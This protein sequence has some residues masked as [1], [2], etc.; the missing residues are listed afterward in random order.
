MP[1]HIKAKSGDIAPTVLLPGDPE[2]ATFIAENFL[3]EPVQYNSYRLLHGYTGFY[4]GNRISVQTTGM[5]A[6]SAAIVIKELIELGAQ[7]FIRI[8]TC[9]DLHGNLTLGQLIIPISA[10]VLNSTTNEIAQFEGYA[11]SPDYDLMQNLV[12]A[13]QNKSLQ[14]KVGTVGTMDLFYHPD[15]T[16]SERCRAMGVLALEMET[17]L[18]FALAARYR[19]RAAALLTV[20]DNIPQGVRAP[21]EIISLG[22]RA[23]TQVALDS[24]LSIKE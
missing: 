5:G 6:P 18:I 20:S 21:A 19:K 16:I 17:S 9:G 15:A 11:P 12:T 23:M 10:C 7:N 4:R 24:T 14:Y 13:A 8:G 22:V 1:I 3:E 2:R